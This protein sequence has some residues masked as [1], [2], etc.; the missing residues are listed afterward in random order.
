[1]GREERFQVAVSL[2]G[3]EV[4][5]KLSRTTID[6][7]PEDQ[8]RA[9]LEA[10][11]Q[12]LASELIPGRTLGLVGETRLS[13]L[14]TRPDYAVNVD[15]ALC[16]FVEVKAPGKGADP[17][18]F[19]DAHDREQ[20]KKLQALPNL[21]YTDGTAFALF[22]DGEI[23]GS[24]VRLEGDIETAGPALAAPSALWPLVEDF[25]TWA[26][27]PPKTARA[28][29]EVS[30]RLC[31]FLRDEAME[32][33]EQGNRALT[34]LAKD[35]RALLFPEANNAQFAD[36]Y[37]QAVT[38]G[39]LVART[40]DIDIGHGI[41]DAARELRKQ[42]SLIG[43]ALM[44]LT[45]D[46]ES[47]PA[48]KTSLNT[49]SRVLDKVSWAEVSKG[50]P[51]AWLYFYEQF[52]EVYDSD[53]RKLTGSYYT[54]PQ[55]VEAMVRLVDEAL[56]D[57]AL[58]DV[59][60]GLASP[61]VTVADPAV[62]TGTFP[63]GVLRRIAQTVESAYGAGA[64]PDAIE[65]AAQ[66]LYG[67]EMQ[68]GPFAVAQLRLFAELRDLLRRDSRPALNL[69]IT[70]TLG[71]PFIEDVRLGSTYEPIAQSRRA[72]NQV[73]KD[74]PITVVIGNPPYKEKAKGRGGWIEDG[75]DGRD[76]TPLQRWMPPAEWGVSAHSKHL[77]NLYVYFWRWATWKVFAAGDREATGREEPERP[78]IVCF[79][80]VSGFLTGPGFQAMRA[81]LRRSCS[82]V[83]VIDCSPEG[84]QPEVATR[85]FQGVQH[86][87]CIVLAARRADTDPDTPA[88]VRFR[89]LAEGR[90]EAKFAELAG[91]GLAGDGWAD[92]AADWR[93]PFRPGPGDVW[94]T[95]PPL[96]ALFAYDGSGVM[97][98]RTWVIAP[99]AQT[100]RQRWDRLVGER[101]PNRKEE[102]FIPQIRQGK[103]ASRHIRKMVVQSIPPQTPR[104]GT[105]LDEQGNCSEP[106]R[107][108]FRTFDRQWLIPD[109]RLINDVRPQLWTV[110]STA[111]IFLT[112]IDDHSPGAG[113][114]ISVCAKVP[115]LHHY[116]GRGGRVFPLWRDAAATEPNVVPALLAAL[117]TRYGCPVGAEDLMAYV[118]ALLAHPAYTARFV[119][120][121]RQP[122]LRVP[123]TA[124]AGLFAEAAA[125]GREVI[126]LHT[127]GERC[128]DP[129]AGRPH[130][131]PRLAENPP[132]VPTDGVIPGDELPDEMRYDP[133]TQRL[134]IGRGYVAAVTPAMCDYEVSGKNVLRQW[135]SYRKADRTRPVIGDR[136]PPSDLEKI[137]PEGWLS[138]YTT[139]LI[140]LLNVLGRLVALEPRQADLLERILAAPLLDRA[141]LEADGAFVAPPQ[142]AAPRRRRGVEGQGQLL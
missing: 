73:K 26:P 29:A 38:F 136:R 22:R 77:Y 53:L 98:G 4:R 104:L 75:L 141:A 27:Q 91:V 18:R 83:W 79:I 115:D 61:Q 71:D 56:C 113:P 127:Y 66:R 124:D 31:R 94:G 137:I 30:A 43:T 110:Y 72:A 51:E 84:H 37:A 100:L 138:E 65:A 81:D 109:A 25:L 116:N 34:D 112:A 99:D 45:D 10:L 102:L 123:L 125:L 122:G 1:M 46:T 133:A 86:P 108:P 8:L 130:R 55:V 117:S 58:F 96:D 93:A 132:H 3:R 63:L 5:E 120:D 16:G 107:Y 57:P 15:R 131:A 119:E 54:P 105:L 95:F 47:E 90:R 40:R 85:L 92:C 88:R 52:L 69:Y 139:D 36:G 87:V 76:R 97:P 142:P 50:D 134:H 118:A 9:P 39:L 101:D 78:G 44:V 49:L 121:L 19:R 128:V 21:L 32:Q 89:A 48:L 7:E 6:G 74:T 62:G 41:A 67:F 12:A 80:T 23:V 70:D 129:A 114:A 28:L 17:R 106:V 24:V 59:P 103:V 68:F 2:Y 111:Q 33:L 126:W 135:F 13:D 14:K 140:D 42:N 20:W 35:W 60:T 64:V 82:D 11:F